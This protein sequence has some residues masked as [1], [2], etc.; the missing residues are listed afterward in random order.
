MELNRSERSI[1]NYLSYF[2]YMS[3]CLTIFAMFGVLVGIYAMMFRNMCTD[4][5]TINRILTICAA[6][7]SYSGWVLKKACDTIEKLSRKKE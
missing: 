3:I 5:R 6:A 2:K 1:V 7:T 4:A